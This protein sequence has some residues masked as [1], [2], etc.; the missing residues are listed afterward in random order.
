MLICSYNMKIRAVAQKIV[1]DV[2]GKSIRRVCSY[3]IV[4]FDSII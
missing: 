4:A 3:I 1:L 2:L